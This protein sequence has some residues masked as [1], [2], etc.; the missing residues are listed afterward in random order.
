MFFFY[1][2]FVTCLFTCKLAVADDFKKFFPIHGQPPVFK[3]Q[4]FSDFPNGDAL[5]NYVPKIGSLTAV[6]I[7]CSL[8]IEPPFDALMT[9]IQ[10]E[11][12]GQPISKSMASLWRQH[13]VSFLFKGASVKARSIVYRSAWTWSFYDTFPRVYNV[14][15][16]AI[17]CAPNTQNR[18][19]EKM[20]TGL[21]WGSINAVID[22]PLERRR[23][24]TVL[25]LSDKHIKLSWYRKIRQYYCGFWPTLTMGSLSCGLFLTQ[26]QFFRTLFI[27]EAHN[28]LWSDHLKTGTIL[29]GSYVLIT[30]P[31]FFLRTTMQKN[32][33]VNSLPLHKAMRTIWRLGPRY[34]YAGWQLR[35]VRS[36][37]LSTLDT[38][39]LHR[40]E[41]LQKSAST[42]GTLRLTSLE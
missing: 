22:T 27:P 8:I 19:L 40:L 15:C 3:I 35:L 14:F 1:R 16:S 7:G 29:G 33:A 17:G 28:A 23:M 32:S 6:R 41:Q 26:E 38:S 2:L 34:F 37:I 25:D 42:P 21:A 30:Q 11:K 4:H 39:M 18:L 9:L 5:K 24:R 36:V 13:G 12:A 10:A 31:L 20:W